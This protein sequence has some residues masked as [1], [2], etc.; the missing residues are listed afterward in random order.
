MVVM[1]LDDL[2]LELLQIGTIIGVG[3]QTSFGFGAIEIEEIK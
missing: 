3:K 2:S 1:G